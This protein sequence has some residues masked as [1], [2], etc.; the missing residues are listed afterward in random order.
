MHDQFINQSTRRA[1]A[2][3]RDIPDAGIAGSTNDAVLRFDVANDAVAGE[4]LTIVHDA[5]N[6]DSVQISLS[7]VY[8]VEFAFSQNVS[9]TTLLGISS[10][11]AA[12]GLTG[13]PAMTIVG[14]LA[15]GGSVL[16]AANSVY[17]NLTSVVAV[18]ALGATLPTVIRAHGTQ[19][20]GTAIEA[21]ELLTNTDC[22]LRVTRIGNVI[23]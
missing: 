20:D 16:P 17:H 22:F 21:A 7:G 9:T 18:S 11:V 23:E 14:M 2:F 10:N 12:A 13:N 3:M 8:L 4:G 1:S 5:V 19:G 6:G 15:V